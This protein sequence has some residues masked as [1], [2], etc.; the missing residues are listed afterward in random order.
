MKL[1]LYLLVIVLGLLL[2][3]FTS[4]GQVPTISTL[5]LSKSNTGTAITIAGTN[6]NITAA[7]NLV[8]FGSTKATVTAATA[9]SLTVTVP[10]GSTAQPLSVTNTATKLTGY[11]SIPF[12]QSFSPATSVGSY[13]FDPAVSFD[14]G[15]NPY[16][17]AICDLDGD[18]KPDL[19]SANSTGNTLT[20]FKNRG[21]SGAIGSSSFADKQSFVTGP[22][23]SVVKTIDVD[24]DGKPDVVVGYHTGNSISVFINTTTAGTISF[25]TRI[26]LIAGPAPAALDVGDIDKDGKPDIVTANTKGN[27]ISVIRNTTTSGAVSFAAPVTFAV[28]SR[29]NAIVLADLNRDNKPDVIVSNFE[30]KT[31]SVFRSTATAGVINTA[32]FAAKFDLAVAGSPTA[33]AAID[34]DGDTNTMPEIIA[35]YYT[36]TKSVVTIRRN[37]IALGATFVATGFATPVEFVT[38]SEPVGI[39]FGDID[40]DQKTD[41]ITTNYNAKSVSVLRN[42]E[43]NKTITTASFAAKVDFAV[44]EVPV[45]AV[46]ADLDADQFP[47]IVVAC[48]GDNNISVLH[49]VN[50]AGSLGPAAPESTASNSAGSF[51]NTDIYDAEWALDAPVGY[52][53]A[54]H[55]GTTINAAG[56]APAN[57]GRFVYFSTL[58]TVSPIQY[59]SGSLQFTAKGSGSI[60]VELITT[61]NMQ[62]YARK[63]FAL[64]SAFQDYS[65]TLP[66]LYPQNEYVFA[67]MVNGGNSS[68]QASAQFKK[69]ITL[70]MQQA[71]MSGM[72]KRFRADASTLIGNVETNY[73]GYSDQF[74]ADRKKYLQ[75]SAY[76]RMRFTTDANKFMVEYV[77]D[78]YDK[79]VVNLFPYTSAQLNVDFNAGGNMIAG[80]HSISDGT[81]VVAGKTYTIAGLK[82]TTPM[83]VWYN[84]AGAPLGAPQSLTNV[85][86]GTVQ[87]P[88]YELTAPAGAV[89]L[90]L[91]VQRITDL[92]NYQSP[93]NDT[94]KAYSEC[95]IKEG[96]VAALTAGGPI[97]FTPYTGIV[98]SRISGIAVYV[99]GK[100]YNYYQVEGTDQAKRVCYLTDNLPPGTKTVEV[101]MNGQGTYTSNGVMQD[102]SIRRTGTY[103]RAVYFP[104]GNTTVFPASTKA[105]N[106]VLF[107][108]DS[109][110]S[111]FNI[112]EDSQNNVW[113]MKIRN[114]PAYGFTGDIFSEGY[115]GRILYTDIDTDVKADAFAAKLISFG[116]KNYWFQIGVNDYGFLTPLHRFYKQ[117]N[118]LVEQMKVLKTDVKIFIQAIGPITYSSANGETYADNGLSA[119]GPS[120]NDFID[121]QH[122]IATAPGHTYCEYV[123]FE[124]LFPATIDNV[125]DGIHPTDAGNALYA[126]G[127]KSKS[128]LLGS[129]PVAV[130]LAFARTAIR[131]FVQ[132]IETVSV[133]AAKGGKVPYTFT[134][135]SNNLPAGLTFNPDGVI[136]GTATESGTFSLYIQLKDA[137]NITITQPF[138]LTVKPVPTV[139]VAPGIIANAQTGVPYTAT[140]RGS[141]GYGKYVISKSGTFPPGISYDVNTNVLSGTCNTAGTYSF[142]LTAVDH[143]GFTGATTYAFV[144][145]TSAPPPLT[146]KFEI[147]AEVNALGE[148][149]ATPNLHDAYSQTIYG[150]YDAYYRGPSGP[151]VYKTSKSMI[152]YAGSLTG[153]TVNFGGV[154]A[155]G[156]FTARFDG[157]QVSPQNSDGKTFTWDAQKLF[158]LTY[159]TY[160]G[161]THPATD[162]YAITASLNANGDAM[163]RGDLGYSYSQGIYAYVDV[164][165]VKNGVEYWLNGFNL[166]TA[167]GNIQSATVNAGH[168]NYAKP[169]SIKIHNYGLS[170]ATSDGTTFIYTTDTSI[171]FN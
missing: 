71:G 4:Y 132:T 8:F 144:V 52:T 18:G 171:P 57:A 149:V 51:I 27:T 26:D 17:V 78:S 44:G 158:N 84:A 129:T 65:W 25:N 106:S 9:T 93:V 31:L 21:S 75:H 28:G 137:N 155:N 96:T 95:I 90:G 150:Y 66:N 114:D 60:E 136:T 87:N 165:V 68:V 34:V 161:P 166:T 30:S 157:Y 6:Y 133:V 33:V 163:I 153:P 48:Y 110:L 103:L 7:N 130:P 23:A 127:V 145:G 85:S 116:V 141:G 13:T 170:P 108:H 56:N 88:L 54:T 94:F 49:T 83:Y 105:T 111:G 146:D 82:T 123:D 89:K 55:D 77:R 67:V 140:L 167:I 16:S 47:D 92:T 160:T 59:I 117:Y 24:G 99:N 168:V 104:A 43:T 152:I 100:L 143:W 76:A 121:V 118:R 124:N 128:T 58:G 134:C 120:A 42:T 107:I 70:S 119:T 74:S 102:P 36:P 62:V 46:V 91:L 98:P 135:L 3:S 35:T 39:A 101:M 79:Q 138:D 112:S 73:A 131:Q 40:G 109:I 139:R 142:T 80:A 53:I 97:V 69:N 63:T 22:G 162:N 20:V 12:V 156:A 38:G 14:A 11:S 151:D 5:S 86:P 154:P 64:T 147:T 61:W 148:L 122:A 126:A 125:A 2:F 15:E 72:F 113:M 115:A 10:Y 50:A 1:Q 81:K 159:G 41:I 37:A 19:L 169:F 45:A 32:T 29:P 164:Y